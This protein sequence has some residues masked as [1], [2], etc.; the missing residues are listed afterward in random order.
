[1]LLL[2]G[3]KNLKTFLSI[4]QL[5]E[6][7]SKS[8]L[9]ENTRHKTDCSSKSRIKLEEAR[10]RATWDFER[11]LMHLQASNDPCNSPACVCKENK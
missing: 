3:D 8:V 11:T 5:Y 2:L 7:E 9:T 1:V 10:G 6:T 4:L